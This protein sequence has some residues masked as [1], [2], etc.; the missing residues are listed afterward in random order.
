MRDSNRFACVLP[1]AVALLLG[2]RISP[3]AAAT[4]APTLSTTE[5]PLES[6]EF[7]EDL[8]HRAFN[9]FWETANPANG[10]VPD[11]YPA[12][13]FASISAV[14]FAL[15]AYPIGVERGYVT[16]AAARDRVLATLRF[17]RD[18]PQGT[19]ARGMTG[20][21]GFYYHFLDM[22][23]GM[24][25]SPRTELSL[26]DTSLLIAGVL[27][28]QSYFDGR[29]P[30]EVELRKIAEELYE[31]VDWTWASRDDGE[32]AL[33]WSLEY[34]FHPRSWRGYNEAMILYVLALGSPTH[35]IPD[36]AWQSYIST[37]Q[38]HWDGPPDERYLAFPPLFGHQY[39]HVWLDFRDIRDAFMRDKGMDY[40]ENSRR[41]TWAQQRYAIANPMHWK[42]YGPLVW[43]ISACDGPADVNLPY[44]GEKRVFHSYAARGIGGAHTYDDGTIAPSALAGSMPFAPEIVL[45]AME[46][47]K[48]QYGDYVYSTYG[49]VDAF[50]PSFDYGVPLMSGRRIP[51]V[52]WFDTNY[53]GIDQGLTVTMAENYRSGFIWRIMRRNPHIRRGLERAG[54]KGGWLEI[55]PGVR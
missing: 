15:T 33:G 3:A 24:R 16:R 5:V 49:F 28:C 1:L 43:G 52:G 13:S 51:G 9:F 31:R 35:S 20:Y 32:I 10:L 40:F 26:I 18:A 50:N 44:D 55:H 17:F 46:Q 21:M 45:P 48:A 4:L 12:P 6:A 8:E 34:G 7:V 27:F 29:D 47:I 19:A 39:S 54:F 2:A 36:T 38:F 25:Y 11:R 41:A 23:T 42:D 14:G 53:L 30:A 22:G 37:N